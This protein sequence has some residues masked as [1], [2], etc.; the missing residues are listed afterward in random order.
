MSG[1]Y[2]S[3][4]RVMNYRNRLPQEALDAPSL[5]ELKARLDGALGNLI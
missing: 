4:E 3:T 5:Q 1:G 2:F